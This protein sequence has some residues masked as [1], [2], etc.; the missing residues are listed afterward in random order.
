MEF[1]STKVEKPEIKSYEEMFKEFEGLL[2]P[3]TYTKFTGEDLERFSVSAELIE[4][5]SIGFC[6]NGFD[7]GIKDPTLCQK[8]EYR[9]WINPRHNTCGFAMARMMTPITR[10][11]KLLSLESRDMVGMSSKKVI[12]PRGSKISYTIYD[13]DKLDVDKPLIVVEG[14]KSAN[15]IKTTYWP[16]TTAIFSNLL[17]GCQADLIKR[18]KRVILIP[19]NGEPGDATITAF[20]SLE[21]KDFRF[22]RV[23]EFTICKDCNS[24]LR[25]GPKVPC[26]VCGSTNTDYGDVFDI[27]KATLHGMVKNYLVDSIKK[28]EYEHDNYKNSNNTFERSNSTLHTEIERR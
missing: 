6:S 14:V 21:L 3:P 26:G 7:T 13:V 16:N 10:E 19:D 8:C 18:F 22:A 11:G 23:P 27:D 20:Q 12:Y 28:I 9:S 25:T 2:Y 15:K 17:K 1:T 24:L 5:N 4:S